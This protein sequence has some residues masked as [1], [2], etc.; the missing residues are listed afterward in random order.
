M[1]VE[2]DDLAYARVGV[3]VGPQTALAG[4]VDGDQDPMLIGVGR[5][6]DHDLPLGEQERELVRNRL[7]IRVVHDHVVAGRPQRP[8]EPEHRADRVAVGVPVRGDR[9]PQRSAAQARGDLRGPDRAAGRPCVDVARW[10]VHVPGSSVGAPGW[11]VV[12]AT[13]S[14]SRAMRRAWSCWVS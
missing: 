4:A 6:G 9:D 13:W 5:P 11:S 12:G 2:V 10:R 8:G 7:C 3:L 14:I 1:M